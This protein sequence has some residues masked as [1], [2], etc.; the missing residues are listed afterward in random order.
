MNARPVAMWLLLA[1]LAVGCDSTTPEDAGTRADGGTA[2][3]DAA[4]PDSGPGATCDTPEVHE[5]E[6]TYYD[7]DGSGNCSFPASPDDLRVAAMNQTDYAGSAACGACVDIEGPTGSVRV[8]IVDRCPECAPGDIDLSPS[9][10][11]AIAERSAG[12][13]PIRWAYVSCDH[14]APLVYHFKDG[15]N[16]YWTAVQVRNHRHRIARFE[17]QN[18]EGAFVEAARAEYNFFVEPAG[19]GEGPFTFRVTDVFGNAMTDTGIPLL[20]EDSASGAGQF[21]ACR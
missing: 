11:D 21:P 13:V 9:A 15:S 17:Y 8:R 10:F 16:P 7:A 1:G 18:A 20:D 4:A 5:G 19:M 6:G 2:P 14:E 3:P 12:R